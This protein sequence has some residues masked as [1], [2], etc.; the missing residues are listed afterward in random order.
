[1]NTSPKFVSLLLAAGLSLSAASAQS[2]TT[3]PVG[4]NK[5]TCLGS[6][7]SII[8]LPLLRPAEF[9][10]SVQ[11]ISG[12]IV[13]IS[14]S[15]NWTNNQ[16]VYVSGT[17]RNTYLALIG[18]KL[19]ALAGVLTG[20]AGSQT[21]SGSGTAFLSQVSVG[22]GLVFNSGYYVVTA[23]SSDNALV[24]N[25]P[26]ASS[27]SG[28]S[29]SVSKSPKEGSFYTV[30]ANSANTLTLDLAGDSLSGVAASTKI[31]LIPQ[32]TLSAIFPATNAGISF[33]PSTSTRSLNTQIL[34][35]N[36]SGSGI[37]LSA[38]QIFYFMNNGWRLAG[39]DPSLD[40]GDTVLPPNG[41]ITVRN[42]GSPT[43]ELTVTGSVLM[44]KSSIPLAT[45]GA[46]FQDTPLA[47]TRP[48][49]VSLNQTLL[50]EGGV[51]VATT[52]TR[53]IQDQVL[54]Y[55]NSL[56]GI[57][58]SASAIY[59]YMNNAWRLAGGDPSI[60]YGGV[61][62]PAGSGIVVRKAPSGNGVTNFWANPPTYN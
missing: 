15:P 36:Y 5:V 57:N 45:Q 55:D 11:S 61:K 60:D 29:A 34:I 50:F 19:T 30:T 13:T 14:G 56:A 49:D 7:D 20:T 43:S 41:Y 31:T 42:S 47:L 25:I 38:S 46:V 44:E 39:A 59:F 35:P 9:V 6:S 3:D 33:T 53:S 40:Y 18:S 12:N 10:G 32:W 24:V 37:N 54:V 4:F 62:I 17:Q 22:D 23:I 21:I 52:S 16:F 8:G 26:V 1:M 51:F 48:I 58:K 28:V 27:I 2:V